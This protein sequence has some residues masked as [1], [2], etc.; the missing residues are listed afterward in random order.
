MHVAHVFFHVFLYVVCVLC[1]CMCVCVCD[2]CVCEMCEMCECVRC[3]RC[4]TE[5]GIG[6]EVV[7]S[8]GQLGS[9]LSRLRISRRGNHRRLHFLRFGNV[10]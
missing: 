5:V 9:R 4:V 1:V 7:V 3:V 8:T 10:L 6:V 2:V